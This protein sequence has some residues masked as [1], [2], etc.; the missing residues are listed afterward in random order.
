MFTTDRAL[1][2]QSWDPW[3]ANATGI[4]ESAACG[5]PI[6]HLFPELAERGHLARLRRVADGV[7]VEILAPALHKYFLPCAPSDRTSRFEQMR[8]HVTIAPLADR[9]GIAGVVVTI[10]DVTDRFDRE[11]RLAAELDSGDEAVRLRAAKS[12][13]AGGASAMLLANSLTDAS[14]RVRRVA[15]EGM[16]DSGGRDVID[17][18]DRSAAKSPPRPRS[19][20]RGALGADPNARRRRDGAR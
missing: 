9:D 3:I 11:K 8:Q 19:A 4:S 10:E 18:L 13:A 1:I 5:Q 17:T 2:V 6:A 16:A 20:Q 15:A 14:W 12:L 7:G